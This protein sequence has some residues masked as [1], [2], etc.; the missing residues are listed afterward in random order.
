MVQDICVAKELVKVLRDIIASSCPQ[1]RLLPTAGAVI[2][3]IV[4]SP[5]TKTDAQICKVQA[6]CL[7]KCRIQLFCNCDAQNVDMVRFVPDVGR[8][9]TLCKCTRRN[10]S[11]IS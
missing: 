5:E 4:Y 6:R 11:F 1:V 3:H 8:L 10:S 2:P 9:I 7:P